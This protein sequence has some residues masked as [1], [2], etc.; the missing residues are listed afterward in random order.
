MKEQTTWIAELESILAQSEVSS[1][2]RFEH[3]KPIIRFLRDLQLKNREMIA[4][5]SMIPN[6]DHQSLSSSPARVSFESD[7]MHHY[8]RQVATTTLMQPEQQR[9]VK[10][11]R[12][13][14][15][16]LSES[17]IHKA[18]K[19]KT[20]ADQAG[21]FKLEQD[22]RSEP[23]L[24][25]SSEEEEDNDDDGTVLNMPPTVI[26]SHRKRTATLKSHKS[27]EHLLALASASPAKP[28]SHRKTT[29]STTGRQGGKVSDSDAL[30]ILSEI[31]NSQ[32]QYKTQSAT[33]FQR[34]GRLGDAAI[35]HDSSNILSEIT[36]P[37]A[38]KSTDPANRVVQ[39]KLSEHRDH[40][41]QYLMTSSEEDDETEQDMPPTVIAPHRKRTTIHE[42]R[43]QSPTLPIS[44]PKPRSHRKTIRPPAQVKVSES[45]ALSV[46]SEIA[47]SPGRTYRRQHE[48]LEDAVHYAPTDDDTWS[49][50][51]PYFDRFRVEYDPKNPRKVIV[52]PN[53]RQSRRGKQEELMYARTVI[54]ENAPV[55][56]SKTVVRPQRRPS[57]DIF[58]TKPAPS[59][60]TKGGSRPATEKTQ[61][62]ST[63]YDGREALIPMQP[64]TRMSNN[65]MQPPLTTIGRRGE[66]ASRRDRPTKSLPSSL[67]LYT[68]AQLEHRI[69]RIIPISREEYDLAPRLVHLQ[70][71]HDHL[72]K[73]IDMMNHKIESSVA[74]RQ[75]TITRIHLTEKDLLMMCHDL[76]EDD[77]RLY[78]N[79][80][81]ALCH[82][83]RLCKRSSKTESGVA[84]FDIILD[85]VLRDEYL[86]H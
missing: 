3:R 53:P 21:Q 77:E 75:D 11:M 69:P 46:L 25:I 34:K 5:S 61:S 20:H 58:R 41:E 42:T 63:N 6:S 52:R 62:I 32:R 67:L 50:V 51:T 59:V 1:V 84:V 18:S 35:R 83:Q 33:P 73:L 22:D 39:F 38:S 70:V 36:S 16:L 74:D 86:D 4:T 24:L 82:F 26:A 85:E 76:F 48:V 19:V 14:D 55:D 54:D 9:D 66:R 40:N 17:P 57:N 31:E 13:D 10:T 71:A 27:P 72:A 30:N 2:D 29:N 65:R 44:S 23:Y 8:G 43:D 28:R 47:T 7:D 81:S 56:F 64:T 15:T 68:Q 49:T 80:I 78:K 60:A 79:M 12:E 37:G 45:D